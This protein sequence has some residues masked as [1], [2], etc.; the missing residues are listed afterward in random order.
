MAQ[1]RQH[2]DLLAR[3]QAARLHSRPRRRRTKA[4]PLARGGRGE[5]E[6]DRVLVAR[7]QLEEQRVAVGV[8]LE[9]RLRAEIEPPAGG[10][11]EAIARR[12]VCARRRRVARA[13]PGEQHA[14]ARDNATSASAGSMSAQERKLSTETLAVVTGWPQAAHCTGAR[15]RFANRLLHGV[16]PTSRNDQNVELQGLRRPC[17]LFDGIRSTGDDSVARCARA[18]GA[19]SGMPRGKDRGDLEA[20]ARQLG[21]PAPEVVADRGGPQV[22]G[23]E[24]DLDPA[25]GSRRRVIGACSSRTAVPSRRCRKSP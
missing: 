14:A 6:Q 18:L 21:D 11:P 5:E 16:M 22:R 7:E 23:E 3:R 8:D 17:D 9:Q 19:P 1:Q 24:T 4:L 13:E 10:Q 12:A 15:R 2:L 25:A 20:I